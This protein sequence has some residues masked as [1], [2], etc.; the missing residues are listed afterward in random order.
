[1]TNPAR[2]I[3]QGLS[4]LL[5]FNAIV[6]CINRLVLKVPRRVL[7]KSWRGVQPLSG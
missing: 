2:E 3:A 7:S 4:F 6:S 1:M 5:L